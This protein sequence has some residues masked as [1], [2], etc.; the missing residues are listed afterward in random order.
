MFARTG[1]LAG[2]G[3][4]VGCHYDF[5]ELYTSPSEPDAG[6]MQSDA[7]MEPETSPPRST[8]LI[9]FWDG[10]PDVDD[11]CMR[12]AETACAQVHEACLADPECVELT[13]CVAQARNPADQMVC[14]ARHL[15]WVTQ[16]DFVS[17]DVN[18]PYGQCVFRD[19]CVSQCESASDL[20]CLGQYDWP[21][22]PDSTVPFHLTLNDSQEFSKHLVGVTVKACPDGDPT[23]ANP[24]A[25]GVTDD[26]G[27]V[28]LTLPTGFS[29]SFAG[30]FELQGADIYPTLLKFSWNIGAPSVQ[31]VTPVNRATYDLFQN[32]LMVAIDPAR[33][34]LQT[35][36]QGC[37]G[38]PA[39][40]IRF[41][42]TGADQ[43]S[44]DWYADMGLPSLNVAETSVLGAG[45][46]FNVL[47]G[48]QT[49]TAL[50]ASDSTVV[51]RAHVPVRP[52]V[53]T[54]VM[55]EPLSI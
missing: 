16:G 32:F 44:K 36:M 53:M 38:L 45:G 21:K 26:R 10:H 52:G 4:L 13:R 18:G 37:A 17:R 2:F 24:V 46:T 39:R 54:I 41:V 47:P 6:A 50:R 34:M 29:R 25:S 43:A 5:N 14:R 23:C 35:R 20:T 42:T 12:C 1:I 9:N 48:Y 40:G 15:T 55:F 31:L 11:E 19:A 30:F 28:Q 8:H 51:G 27:Y 33:G 7:M 49:V 22:T 3:L